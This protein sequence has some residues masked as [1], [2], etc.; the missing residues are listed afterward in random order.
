M[1]HRIRRANLERL[2][3]RQLLAADLLAHWVASDLDLLHEDGASISQWT[4]AIGNISAAGTGNPR[5]VKNVF[6]GNSIVRFDPSNGD[7]FFHIAGTDSPMSGVDDFTIA[8]VFASSA[9]LSVINS[10]VWFDHTGL[11]DANRF[12][13]AADWGLSL[14]G[15]GQ[16]AVG[17]GNPA[18]TQFSTSEELLDGLAHVV[19]F[20]RSSNTISLYVDGQVDTRSDAGTA[21]RGTFDM[22]IGRL[23]SGNLP[24][25]GDIAEI[26]VYNDDLTA[27]EATTLNTELFGRYRNLQP[28]ASDDLYVIDEDTTLIVDDIQG[29]LNNDSDP[30]NSALT[31]TLIERPM[32][33]LMLRPDGSFTYK[34]D[35]DFFGS[36]TFTYRASDGQEES[37]IATVSLEILPLIDAPRATVDS[38]LVGSQITSKDANRGVLANDSHPDQK[39][40]MSVLVQD[41]KHGTLNL[42]TDGSFTYEPNSGFDGSDRFTYKLEDSDE[43][44]EIVSVD[45]II[46]ETPTLISEVMASNAATLPTRTRS[47]NTEDF[48]GT[49]IFPDWIE[50]VNLWDKPVDIGGMHLTDNTDDRTKWKIPPGTI[51]PANGH[52]TVFASGLNITAPELDERGYLHTNFRLAADGEFL[53]LTDSD[54]IIVHALSE[55]VPPQFTD[56]SYGLAGSLIVTFMREP[57]PGTSNDVDDSQSGPIV[58]RVTQNP[59]SLSDDVDLVVTA[60]VQSRRDPVE[61]VRLAYRAMFRDEATIPMLDD[62][63]GADVQAGDGVYSVLIPHFVADPGEMLRWRVMATDTRQV[64]TVEPPFLDRSGNRQSP[65]YYGTIIEDPQL[66]SLLA[67][68]HWFVESSEDADRVN[69]AGARASVY[70]DGEFYDNVFSRVRGSS[71]RGVIK[72]P[73]KFDFNPGH[74]FRY[75][76]D[77][78]RVSE[79]NVNST[80]QDKAYIRQQLAHELIADAGT[81]SSDAFTWRIQQNGEFFSVASFI[82]QVDQD[83]LQRRNLDPNGALYK[84]FNGITSSEPGVEKRTRR[85]EDN[86]DLSSLVKGLSQDNPDTATYLF[87]NID[88]PA[89]INYVVSGVIAM[90]WDRTI[91]N[92]YVYR[93]TNDTGEW[94]QLPWDLDL[95]IGNI[96]YSDEIRGGDFLVG[97]HEFSGLASG[98][99]MID[100]LLENPRTHQMFLR[101][102][103][104]LMDQLLQPADTPIENRLLERRVNELAAVVGPDADLDFDKWG[105]VFGVERDFPTAINLIKTNFLDQRRVFLYETHGAPQGAGIPDAQVGHPTIDITHIEFAP[106]SGNSQQEYIRLENTNPFA[107]DITGW[108]LAGAVELTFDPGTVIPAGDVL[109]AVKDVATFRTRT[110]GPSGGQG[111][112][113]QGGYR[114]QLPDAGGTVQLVATDGSIVAQQVYTSDVPSIAPFLR[115]SEVHYN[116]A[117]ASTYEIAAGHNDRDDFEFIELVNIGIEPIEL[118]DARLVKAIIGETDE[119]VEF[120]FSSGQITQLA[121][122]D[123]VLVVEDLA[124]FELRYGSELPVAGQ[125]RGGLGNEGE[126]ITLTAGNAT[127]H[128]FAYDDSWFSQSNSNG[129]SL[130][131]VNPSHTDTASWKNRESW[132]P[133]S[134]LGG[135]PGAPS[136]DADFN[137]DGLINAADIDKLYAEIRNMTHL[138]EFDITGDGSVNSSDVAQLV[139]GVLTTQ[140]GDA[141]LDGSV[142]DIDFQLLASQFGTKA[143][144]SGGDFNGDG[145]VSFGDFVL[146]TN[147]FGSDL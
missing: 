124:A 25:S 99:R 9:K 100:T 56:V 35:P 62:G 28:N 121:S 55:T 143:S 49:D 92:F 88:L 59:G 66:Q 77:D 17:L 31:V 21:A 112:F 69:G 6:N 98:N 120:D 72:K 96:F 8:L 85:N 87:D 136:I 57:T 33:N 11:I 78:H 64:T 23:A 95:T 118:T 113:V 29:V 4:D 13:F 137:D 144:W 123:H 27:E 47:P 146:L 34:P 145:I 116:P 97:P 93:D 101:R 53:A 60:S 70:F 81:P 83:F 91:K 42:A 82:E 1:Y 50:L 51:I 104:T 105:A 20:S 117:D 119:G 14:T 39:P 3:T 24:F 30:E 75:G 84:I 128:Q 79:I 71:A 103:R 43:E 114:Q 133:S 106:D 54:G 32:G 142:D 16:I 5:L 36:D 115:I 38:Y 102:L 48:T 2:E 109:Y 67:T 132:R 40:F 122:G 63:L 68:L 10:D 19:I 26:H 44:S 90:D 138:A 139:E 111:L 94:T 61:S 15:R 107:V 86:S 131:M 52:W 135:T 125:W 41:V 130:E 140:F 127:I 110:K 141:N 73:Y 74:E 147:S 134:R 76:D 108:R 37:Q 89:A 80:Y 22:I 12:G 45:L 65:E 126:T 7:D 18:K 46:S 129:S 58:T